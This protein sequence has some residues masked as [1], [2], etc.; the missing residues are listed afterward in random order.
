MV[1]MS[2][3][4]AERLSVAMPIGR[5]RPALTRAFKAVTPVQNI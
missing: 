2:G 5:R 4:N 3:I 1:G